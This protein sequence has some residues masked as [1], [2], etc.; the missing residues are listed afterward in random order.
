MSSTTTGIDVSGDI[1]ERINSALSSGKPVA[2]TYVDGNGRPHMSLRGST[3]V[4]GKDQ[5][6]WWIRHPEGL[7]EAIKSNPQVG[8]LYRD[9][10]AR[11]TIILYGRAHVEEASGVRDKVYEDSPEAERNHDP[12]RHGIAVVVDLDE[13]SSITVGSPPVHMSRA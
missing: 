7:V 9:S 3:H 8:L 6:A 10:A 1:A 5:V 11:T 12:D 4:H 2:V 13:V